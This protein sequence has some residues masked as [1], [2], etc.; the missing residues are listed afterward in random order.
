MAEEFGGRI[1]DHALAEVRVALDFARPL[2]RGA[3]GYTMEYD[4]SIWLLRARALV[5]AWGTP[6]AHRARVLEHLAGS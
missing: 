2:V 5:G 3:I 4:L 6:T 1:A